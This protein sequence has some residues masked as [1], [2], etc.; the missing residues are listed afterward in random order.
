MYFYAKIYDFTQNLLVFRQKIV[1]LPKNLVFLL[2]NAFFSLRIYILA[3]NYIFRKI[4]L[5]FAFLLI[6]YDFSKGDEEE[7]ARKDRLKDKDQFDHEKA[8]QKARELE[9]KF[10]PEFYNFSGKILLSNNF[11]VF[12]LFF[13]K[14]WYF[15][16][17]FY[18]KFD[19]SWESKI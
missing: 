9:V 1:F 2:K 7:E 12:F 16:V 17:N 4:W 10:F 5:V 14:T 11:F 19:I 18:E 15:T 6:F 13:I 8:A 3:K